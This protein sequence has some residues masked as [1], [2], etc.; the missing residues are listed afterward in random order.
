MRLATAR[1]TLVAVL[2]A[3]P[4]TAG[5]DVQ[6]FALGHVD[7]LGV[8]GSV[9]LETL[10]AT[11]RR[12]PLPPRTL[13]DLHVRI[14]S[15]LDDDVKVARQNARWRLEAARQGAAVDTGKSSYD[16]N[17]WGALL[18]VVVGSISYSTDTRL[19]RAKG[20]VAFLDGLYIRTRALLDDVPESDE[21]VSAELLGRWGRLATE[22]WSNTACPG[23]R[24]P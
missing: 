17:P 21:P 8:A 3:T 10:P 1:I 6:S 9:P 11:G 18:T 5:A 24:G 7:L 22:L 2:V 19:R 23:K 4:S 20:C 13:R 15:F 16:G 12:E 14:A